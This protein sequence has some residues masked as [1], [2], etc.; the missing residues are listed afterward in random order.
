MIIRAKNFEIIDDLE[1][2]LKD[3]ITVIVGASNN[4]KSSIIRLLRAILYNLNGDASI[5]Q[6]QDAYTLGIIDNGSKVIVKRDMT[7][8]NKTVYSVNGTILKKVGRN[9]VPEVEDALN[10]K[11][12]DINKKKVEL[13]FITQMA[14][15]FLI[16]ETGSFIYDF[17]SS[18]SNQTDFSELLKLMKT[19]Q[20]EIS[21]NKKNLEGQT[22]VL[23]DM[24]Q[25]SKDTYEKLQDVNTV[26]D[27]IFDFDTKIQ[28]LQKLEDTIKSL[29]YADANIFNLNNKMD[30]LLERIKVLSDLDNIISNYNDNLEMLNFCD[31]IKSIEDKILSQSITL[32]MLDDL[33]TE[34]D[35]TSLIEL[36]DICNSKAQDLIDFQG[37]LDNINNILELTD[38]LKNVNK[39]NE[40]VLNAINEVLFLKDQSTEI[41]AECLALSN[42]INK[43]QDLV[44]SLTSET[45]KYNDTVDTLLNIK[46]ELAEFDICPVC[47]STLKED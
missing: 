34:L 33:N 5:Q 37:S 1:L 29:E 26:T 45:F 13:N 44:H 14:F 46:K 28:Y 36:Q 39:S 47:G 10:I 20:K 3:G 16:G 18:S 42:N 6:G 8:S 9:I 2:E 4:G 11:V 41:Q 30:Y 19:D 25:T 23:K 17:L 12:V 38:S 7:A 22:D 31:Y 43:V 40:K 15:P 24:F 21:D 32:R 27:M 35:L